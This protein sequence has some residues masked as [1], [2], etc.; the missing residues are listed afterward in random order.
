MTRSRPFVWVVLAGVL[1]PLLFPRSLQA[2]DCSVGAQGVN[3]GAY[4]PAAFANLDSAGGIDVRCDAST[5]F[6]VALS[7]G[8]GS[9]DARAMHAG[10]YVLLYNLYTSPSRTT[11]WGDGSGGSATVPGDGM[12]GSL[13]VYGRIPARQNGH[14]GSYTDTV[15]V[16]LTF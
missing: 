11:V 15:V 13:T 8:S 9:F 7:T 5:A 10:G 12:G 16:T 6:S 14:V 2:A 3:F 1:L 4:D